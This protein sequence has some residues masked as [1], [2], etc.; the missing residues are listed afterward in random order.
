QGC[1]TLLGQRSAGDNA[2][3]ASN[4]DR[5]T[6][7]C[8]V[9]RARSRAWSWKSRDGT[10]SP[11]GARVIC[12]LDSSASRPGRFTRYMYSATT[13][14]GPEVVLPSS[15]PLE[16]RYT[17]AWVLQPS[18]RALRIS[19][20]PLSRALERQSTRS[21]SVG[22]SRAAGTWSQVEAKKC[23][24]YPRLARNR[25]TRIRVPQGELEQCRREAFRLVS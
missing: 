12:T 1:R 9:M 5:A 15:R 23:S 11:S 16:T 13:T 3:L 8:S 22:L 10:I 2:S 25:R 7:A 21:R 14:S 4:R 18:R 24:S 19:T 17:H 20:G 6:Y